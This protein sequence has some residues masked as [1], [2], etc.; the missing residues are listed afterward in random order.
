MTP[1]LIVGQALRRVCAALLEPRDPLPGSRSR[2]L[3]LLMERSEP[4]PPPAGYPT[5]RNW[6]EPDQRVRTGIQR[7][8]EEQ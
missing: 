2:A 7:A 8:M 1:L 6:T 3:R 4:V 5:A